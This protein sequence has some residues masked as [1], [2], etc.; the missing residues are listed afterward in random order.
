V[1]DEGGYFI[2]RHHQQMP[3][4]RQEKSAERMKAWLLL[5]Q[6]TNVMSRLPSF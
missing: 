3:Y 2:C 4:I 5:P 6:K 1:A